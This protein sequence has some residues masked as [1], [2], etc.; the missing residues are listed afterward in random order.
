MLPLSARKAF[1]SGGRYQI[2]E[3]CKDLVREKA[4]LNAPIQLLVP[5]RLIGVFV[6]NEQGFVSRPNSEGSLFRCS[7]SIVA[8]Y[9]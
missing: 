1:N 3:S 8:L 4:F 2:G 9:P 5:Y 6:S 7:A